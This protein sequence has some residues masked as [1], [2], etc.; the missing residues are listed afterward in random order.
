MNR[1]EALTFAFND[2]ARPAHEREAALAALRNLATDGDDPTECRQAQ[3]AVNSLDGNHPQ[4][5]P[6]PLESELLFAYHCA[7]LGDVQ[8]C[9]LHEF[10]SEHRGN[11][12]ADR[13]YQKWLSVSPAAQSKLKEMKRHLQNYF[14]AGYDLLLAR[15]KAALD[16]GSDMVAAN[17]EALT[18]YRS[19]ADS[20]ILPEPMKPHFQEMIAALAARCGGQRDS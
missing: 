14:L 13:L 11:P 9:H 2:A 5:A 10:L 19:W 4:D 12:D 7:T 20:V 8:H 15:Y 6:C 1:I 3:A 16:A 17:R 18:F